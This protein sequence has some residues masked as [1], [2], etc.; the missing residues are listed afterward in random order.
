LH[1]SARPYLKRRGTERIVVGTALAATS[2][3]LLLCGVEEPVEYVFGDRSDVWLL[4][5][6]LVGMSRR[7]GDQEELLPT[8][9]L[10]HNDVITASRGLK[11]A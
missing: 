1:G 10:T 3:V 7:R 5:L 9:K 2:G 8:G 6:G 11:A 4:H